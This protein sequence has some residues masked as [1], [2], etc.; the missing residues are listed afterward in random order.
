MSA[1][2]KDKNDWLNCESCN[3]FVPRLNFSK[4]GNNCENGI[5]EQDG[6][7]YG[8]IK[9]GILHGICRSYCQETDGKL[10]TYKPDYIIAHPTTLKVC[11]LSIASTVMVSF[12]SK[13]VYGTLWSSKSVPVDSLSLM[14]SKIQT[15]HVEE[16][17]KITLEKISNPPILA[18]SILLQ[19]LSGFSAFNSIILNELKVTISGI[20]DNTVLVKNEIVSCLSYGTDVYFKI[21]D[22]NTEDDIDNQLCKQLSQLEIAGNIQNH[23]FHGAPT[24]FLMEHTKLTIKLPFVDVDNKTQ[25]PVVRNQNI[26]GLYQQKAAL[27]DLIKSPFTNHEIYLQCGVEIPK[28]VIVHGPSGTGKTILV[29]SYISA[30]ENVD[31]T[32]VNG[33]EL[34]SK[35]FGETEQK[36]RDI[37]NNAVE[38]APSVLMIDEFDTVCPKRT[39]SSN[40]S[41]KRVVATFCTLLD[42]I[43][44]ESLFV[45][46]ALTNQ[47]DGIDPVLRRPGR[48]EKE[49]EF[50]VPNGSERYDIFVKLLLTIQHNLTE[51]DIKELAG[52]TH[53]YVGA[54]ISALCKEAGG[55]AVRECIANKSDYASE[56]LVALKHFKSSMCIV[57]PSAL[58]AMTVDIPKVYWSD[59]GGQKDV[60]QKLKE[61][62]EW[63]LK[64]PDAF[65]RLGIKPPRGLLMY[66]PPGCSKTMMAKALATESSL[67]FISI[68][69]PEL[70]NKYLGESE[71]AVREVF[72]KARMSA[73]SIVFFDE[74]DALGVQRSG[75]EKGSGNV[76]DRVLAQL[77]TELDGVESL[78]GVIVVAATNRPD[79]IDPALV[80]PGRIDRLIYVPLPNAESR[81]EIFEVMFRSMSVSK[82]LSLEYLIENTVNYSGAEICSIC[83]EAGLCA[84]RENIRSEFVEEKHFAQALQ[85]IKPGTSKE[86]IDYYDTFSTKTFSK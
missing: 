47:L 3:C 85:Q 76:G 57:G 84:L 39:S 28:G 63:P 82:N 69:G 61:A 23:K 68:K 36:L 58:K 34:T 80:R 15:L 53:G 49:V 16:G 37:F 22:I 59:V 33:P 13:K 32:I 65:T 56:L 52:N 10:P 54:D 1:K 2:K 9:N 30:L 66:G 79:I 50:N 46:I 25:K 11:N 8:F 60:K 4:H 21:E 6:V 81:K 45:V 7:G 18:N 67:N 44:Q 73:P 19:I 64:H 51:D 40:E 78:N 42:N 14:S 74:I 24:L 29:N 17:H 27:D 43:P 62:I 72:R 38:K 83:H 86:V 31:I 35:Y 77:L 26:G 5:I 20:L 55:L 75:K 12:N 70:F 41:E 48:F 71:R